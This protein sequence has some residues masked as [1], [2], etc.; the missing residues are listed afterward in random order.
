MGFPEHTNTILNWNEVLLLRHNTAAK[1]AQ[2]NTCHGR[3]A[4]AGS[5][6]GSDSAAMP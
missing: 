3:L 5:V 4:G 2:N 1:H 6:H